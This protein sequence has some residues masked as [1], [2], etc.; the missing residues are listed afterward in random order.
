MGDHP[1]SAELERLLHGGLGRDEMRA[2]VRHLL[3]GCATCR[4]ALATYSHLLFPRRPSDVP[5][6][7]PSR[8]RCAPGDAEASRTAPLASRT[9]SLLT[10]CPHTSPTGFPAA[11]PEASGPM[12]SPQTPPALAS[13]QAPATL[14]I[15]EKLEPAEEAAALATSETSETPAID[16]AYE[17]AIDRALA[18]VVRYGTEA[19]RESKRV[20]Q[21]LA[22]LERKGVAG[23][24]EMPAHLRGL[25]GYEALLER[26]WSL[27]FDDPRQ[28]VQLCELASVVAAGLSPSRYGGERVRDFQCRAAIELANAYR[29]IGRPAEAQAALNEA[30]EFFRMGTQDRLMAA[31]LF[32]IQAQVSGDRRNFETALAAFDSAIKVYRDYGEPYQVGDTLI[33]KGMYCGYACR[34]DEALELLTEGL[35]LIDP[36]THPELALLAVHNLA[37]I[38]VDST[39][40]REARTLLWRN[41][42]LYRS[43]GGRVL[44]L[45]LRLLEGRIHAGID[46]PERADRDFEEARR[47]FAELGQPYM[48][49]LVLLDLAALHIRQGRDADARREALEAADTF[50]GLN[51]G[52]EAAVAM[53]LLKSTVKFRLATTAVLLEEMAEFM[54]AA[55]HDP[56]VSFHKYFS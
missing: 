51:I 48:A 44:C 22:V 33:K 4:A 42:P 43:Y 49:T 1:T 12:G 47:G 41:L 24:C 19:T 18:S 38:L 17:R 7:R 46:E 5:S 13:P 53:M 35:A 21:V 11:V 10:A 6:G 3:T 27:R 14:V 34:L 52:R 28:M 30:L 9:I 15:S 20:K 50:L 39:R 25:A 31:R 36:T 56:Q 40:F 16:A 26:S 29:V 32:V 55:E 2:V 37:N 54:R 8:E 45:R 23:F